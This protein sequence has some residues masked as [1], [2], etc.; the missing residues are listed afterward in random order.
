ME[1]GNGGNVRLPNGNSNVN[2]TLWRFQIPSHSSSAAE[3]RTVPRPITNLALPFLSALAL[4]RFFEWIF[5]RYVC[6]GPFEYKIHVHRA[7]ARS[8]KTVRRMAV[9]YIL[10]V[11]D[12]QHWLY[13][14]LS[15]RA[16]AQRCALHEGL[17]MGVSKLE[18]YDQRS[19]ILDVQSPLSKITLPMLCT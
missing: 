10:D 11:P 19:A 17:L 3:R 6:I 15:L 9:R 16:H 7:C 14:H 18:N 13:S 1:M 4:L 12:P 2:D 5:L 8:M